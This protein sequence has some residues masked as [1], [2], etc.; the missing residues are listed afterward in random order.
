MSLVDQALDKLK[1]QEAA[2]PGVVLTRGSSMNPKPIRWLWKNYLARGK[3]HILA[4]PPGLGKTTIA[5]GAFAATVSIGGRW[6][7]GTQCELGNV[8]IWSGE[9]DYN[10]TL[11]TRLMGC[12][13]DPKR[14]YFVTAAIGENGPRAFDPRKDMGHLLAA[15]EE[16]GGASL[17]VV[18][19]VVSTVSGDGN[20]NSDVRQSLQPL[21]D[22]AAA[23]NFAAVGITHLS[24]GGKATRE[25][26]DRIIGSVAFSAVARVAFIAE[27]ITDEEGN[28]RRILVRAKSNIGLDGGGFEY[29]LDQL[30]VLP[31]IEASRISWGK[32]VEGTVRELLSEPEPQGEQKS[33][34]DEAK[35]HLRNALVD[36][37]VQ[38]K[39]LEQ[40]A[41]QAGISW[42]SIRRAS[43]DLLIIKRKSMDAWY[44]SLA[45]P[46]C[47]TS[48]TE[49][50]E[51]LEQVE[52]VTSDFSPT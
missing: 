50:V 4:G 17:V 45:R 21:V 43:N 47:A 34:L 9:D 6:P 7:D 2:M 33:A 52:Q 48:P 16:I 19:P 30:E 32:E 40:D 36:G 20:S 26:L 13:G 51:Q 11:V 46:T 22:A 38:S 35:A 8:V 41:K 42:A 37:P 49:K 1:A 3:L 27:R 15:I 12:G 10:D 23:G 29:H 25:P 39:K 28:Q 18:D 24:K 31:G 5:A 44:W 14:V